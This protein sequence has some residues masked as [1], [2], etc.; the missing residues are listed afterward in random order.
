MESTLPIRASTGF[1]VRLDQAFFEAILIAILVCFSPL[2]SVAY[3]API[4]VVAWFLFRS[5]DHGSLGRAASWTG[6]WV[7]IIAAR[8]LFNPDYA[9]PNAVLT[10]LTYSSF[11]IPFVVPTRAL[12]TPDVRARLVSLARWVI[13]VEA[14]VGIAQALYGFTRTGSFSSANG[15]YVKGTISLALVRDNALSNPMFAVNIAFLLLLILPEVMQAQRYRIPFVIGLLALGLASVVHVLVF[16]FV[17]LVAAVVICRPPLF[18]KISTVTTAAIVVGCL[19]TIFLLLRSN[20]ALIPQAYQKFSN[21]RATPRTKM[22]ERVRHEMV[23]QY[24]YLPYVGIGPGQFTSRAG[25]I[26][27][28]MFF[29]SPSDPRPLPLLHPTV[30]PAQ[31]KY[32]IDLW[33]QTTTLK[34]YGSTDH[35]FFSWLSVYTEFGL[36]VFAAIVAGLGVLVIRARRAAR[37]VAVNRWLAVSFVSGILML[38]LLGFQ[39]NYWE[40]PQAILIGVMTLKVTYAQITATTPESQTSDEATLTSEPIEPNSP[41]A[42][43]S[44]A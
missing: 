20:F 36:P 24:P 15:D 42:A 28:G 11:A 40:V 34:Y 12:A 39:E 35:P 2:K 1:L 19:L 25:L 26:G 38:F 14:P 10:L 16:T 30:S 29:G 31:Q 27:T 7:A 8:G 17:A 21:P 44:P 5:A 33:I 4:M 13:L 3:F 43:N 23:D 32:L 9:V 37:R 18:A 6:I 41:L 22:I